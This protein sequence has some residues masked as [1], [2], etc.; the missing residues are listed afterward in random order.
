MGNG[1]IAPRILNLD[2]RW[3]WVAGFTSRKFYFRRDSLRYVWDGR[4]GGP[5]VVAKRKCLCPRRV[6]NPRSSSP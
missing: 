4:L 3:R 6:S 2:T 5:D 1:G